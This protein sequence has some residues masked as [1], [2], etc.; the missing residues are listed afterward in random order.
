M[1][2]WVTLHR[3]HKR[4]FAGR[5]AKSTDARWNKRLLEWRPW[6]PA[7]RRIGRPCTRWADC[8]THAAGGNWTEHA[9][10]HVLWLTLTFTRVQRVKASELSDFAFNVF[11]FLMPSFGQMAGA[12]LAPHIG[13]YTLPSPYLAQ[14]MTCKRV[15]L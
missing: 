6:F 7:G 13:H 5:C 8:I 2:D 10:D 15:A 3:K 12:C 9:T 1:V 11:C 4:R 14:Q